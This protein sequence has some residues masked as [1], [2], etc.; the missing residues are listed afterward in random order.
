MITKEQ[1]DRLKMKEQEIADNM[2]SIKHR[3]VVFSG[4][5]GVG[6][7]TVSVNLAYGLRTRGFKIGIL[8]ADI[9]GP[10]VP[11]MLGLWGQPY[12]KDKRLMPPI[13]HDVKVISAAS[14]V[15]P[16]E[17]IAWR[18]PM[19]SK[20]L[21]QFLGE[22]EW[23]PLDFLIADLPPGT[24][25]EI[26]T[27]TQQMDPDLA[28]IVTTPQEL[29]LI[30]SARAI[31]LAKKIKIPKIG[32]IENM[33]GFRCPECGNKIDLFDS[34]GGEKQA[35]Q[36]NVSFLGA[37]PIDIEARKKADKG[38]PIILDNRNADLSTAIMEVIEKVE[39]MLENTI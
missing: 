33:S 12:G 25:D 13:C 39:S 23:G 7:T 29:S 34:G 26:I 1:K 17:P 31:N 15:S 18:G 36:M 11:K 19:R 24:G 5:G 9:T 8:D 37:L 30:D 16:D 3:I 20:L 2:H 4:K 10:N 6:K 38:K 22:V 21:Y 35:E 32:V 14:L 27:L 28:I